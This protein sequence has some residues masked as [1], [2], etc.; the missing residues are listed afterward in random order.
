MD[1][2]KTVAETV[3]QPP[4]K[5]EAGTVSGLVG[6]S[7]AAIG[8]VAFN[9]GYLDLYL[10]FIPLLCIGVLLRVEVGKD[11]FLSL[12][13]FAVTSSLLYTVG[14]FA[15][16][17]LFAGIMLSLP[18]ALGLRL[19]GV[20][21]VP[22]TVRDD[23]RPVRR[24]LELCALLQ[25][26]L[27][28]RYIVYRSSGG[29]IPIQIGEFEELARFMLSEASGWAIF[30]LGY[31]VQHRVRYG[32]LYT[33]GL[34]FAG[35]FPT[36]L[37]TGLLLITPYVAIMTLG[38]N[39]FGIAGLYLSAVPVGAAHVLMR[40]LTLRR[41]EIER[42]NRR[43]QVM[44]IDMAR[45][46]RMAAIGQ[47]SSTISHQILQKIGLL[48]L[49]CDLLR[50]TLEDDQPQADETR[51]EAQQ[52]VEQLDAAIT[53]LNT[54]LSDLLVF[55]RDFAIHR[56]GGS[57]TELVR[58]AGHEIEEA[59]RSRGITMQYQFDERIVTARVPFDRIKLK[60]AILNLLTNALEA[61][62]NSGQITLGV[63]GMGKSVQ[64]LVADTGTGIPQDVREQIFAPFV[65]T[66]KT[67]SGLGLAFTQKIIELHN[68]TVSAHNNSDRGA[69]FTLEIPFS[70]QDGR[71]E[72]PV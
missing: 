24:V 43:L 25:I 57:L 15:L 10:A 8:L 40:T 30:A 53:D 61:S 12:L 59:A 51:G 20:D 2:A 68:G 67:G 42:Q 4:T 56:E 21:A 65:S 48:G 7:L 35:N 71:S 27:L 11:W 34:D 63:R 31:G 1:E 39:T 60:Q 45:S 66:K 46:E 16:P 54:T 23:A 33:A 13:L 52:R 55:S 70:E 14:L 69:T 32:S 9:L 19:W 64:V 72:M 38:V 50:D 28:T 3:G 49:Q 5:L 62:P 29:K 18:V 44:N 26:A 58:E 41:K 37:I 22:Q 17:L 36:L 47:M 6:L